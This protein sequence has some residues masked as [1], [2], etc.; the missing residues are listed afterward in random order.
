M[1][2]KRWELAMRVIAEDNG[3]GQIDVSLGLSPEEMD[4]LILNLKDLR[5]SSD[6]HQHFH[7]SGNFDGKC[8][9]GEFTFYRKTS[10]ELDDMH[11]SSR[12]YAPGESITLPSETA[13]YK[14]WTIISSKKEYLVT[15]FILT[16]AAIIAY[17]F[18]YS[19]FLKI[20]S[21]AFLFLNVY[22]FEISTRKLSVSLFLGLTI[23]GG[24][25]F[26]VLFPSTSIY[27]LM[28]WFAAL[29][30]TA[31]VPRLFSAIRCSN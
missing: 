16:S 23:I 7:I 4:G 3:N 28:F 27:V 8:R 10:D 1:L 15:H 13:G 22:L 18:L 6:M 19:E 12:S 24:A 31:L 21:G 9:V 5:T 17:F 29:L 14:I 30:N 11:V 20:L 26:C 2:M 25:V